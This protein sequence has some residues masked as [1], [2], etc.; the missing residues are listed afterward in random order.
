MTVSLHQAAAS[1]TAHARWQELISE[2]LA[3]GAVPG[4]K[5]QDMSFAAIQAGMMAQPGVTGSGTSNAY[6]VPKA[7]TYTNFA[8]GELKQT[9]VDTHVALEGPGFFEVEMPDGSTAYTRD[10]EFRLNARKELVTK[11]GYLVAGDGGT[12]QMDTT[13]NG[14]ISISPSGE[15][16]QNGIRKGKL[17]LVTFADPQLLTPSGSGLFKAEDSRVTQTTDEK[18]TVREGWLESSNA[19]TSLEMANLITAMRSFEASQKVVQLH[20]D[21]LGRLISDL[22]NTN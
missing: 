18:P 3:A 8:V 12:L 5:K 16:S 22:G 14:P 19:N 1:M 13:N 6:L 4:F 11:H 10:G 7:S 20:D 21:R 17:K 2:N 9:G 15:V